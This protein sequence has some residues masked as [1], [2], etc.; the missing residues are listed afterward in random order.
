MAVFNVSFLN[1][2]MRSSGGSNSG[3]L[4][5]QLSIL[6]NELGKD[7]FLSPG[8]YDLLIE[9]ARTIQSMPGLSASQKSEYNVKIS[10]FE[11]QKSV[12]VLSKEGD[13]GFMNRSS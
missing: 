8:D 10:A 12:G 11:K 7:G 5:D 2:A 9:K 6:Q 3:L 13:I 1:P 4:A